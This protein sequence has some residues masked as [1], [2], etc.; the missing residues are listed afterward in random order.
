MRP[1]QARTLLGLAPDAD[2]DAIRRRYHLL[3]RDRHPDAGGDVDEFRLLQQA[4]AVLVQE[5]GGDL[6]TTT[7]KVDRAAAN[8]AAMDREREE[9]ERIPPVDPTAVD[10][11]GELPSA[12]TPLDAPLLA[13]AATHGTGPLGRVAAVTRGRKGLLNK[14]AH[15]LDDNLTVRLEV[16]VRV[17]EPGAGGRA[18]RDGAGQDLG[19]QLQATGKRGRHMMDHLRGRHGWWVVRHSSDLVVAS[20]RVPLTPDVRVNALR[21]AAFA[22]EALDT[23][24]W[25]LERWRLVE[26]LAR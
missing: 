17:G 8:R 1:A 19:V 13:L 24:D 16:G 25:P 18:G 26:P 12:P 14:V 5:G 22:E 23:L 6:V 10:W 4:Y 11:D 3:A 7:S 15:A 2:A 9:R 20:R 21:A